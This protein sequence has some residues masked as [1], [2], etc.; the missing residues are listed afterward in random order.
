MPSAESGLQEPEL[1]EQI[2]TLMRACRTLSLATLSAPFDAQRGAD[3]KTP[4]PWACELFFVSD[5]DLVLYFISSPDSRHSQDLL[6]SPQVAVTLSQKASD[7]F[8]VKG[9]QISGEASRVPDSLRP[10]VLALY[11]QKSPQLQALYRQPANA[12]E[13]LIRQ[14]L[15]NSCFYAI[16]PRW[17]RLI[18]NSRHFASKR[19]LRL[20]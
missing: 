15:I 3:Q 9:L 7:W 10:A 4:E 20:D 2:N 5:A 13:E 14:R 11:L 18:D 17:I 8:C 16:R 1:R 19:E 6:R 12:A